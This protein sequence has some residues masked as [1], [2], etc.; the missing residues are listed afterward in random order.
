MIINPVLPLWLLVIMAVALI[1]FGI[2]QVVAAPAGKGL[3]RVWILRVVMV[4]LL[5]TVAIRPTIPG[6]GQGPTVSGGLEVYFVVD[7]TSSMAAEDYGDTYVDDEGFTR[8]ETRLD[9]VKTDIASIAEQLEGAEFSLVTFDAVAIQRVPLTSDATALLSATSVMRQEI[10]GY[11]QGSSIDAPLELVDSLLQ[12]AI[13]LNPDRDRVVFYFGDGEQT[14]GADPESFAKLAGYIAGGA[15]LGY[16]TAEGG[17]MVEF[18]G[19]D[20]SGDERYY[21]QDYSLSPVG[22]AISRIDEEKLATI[23]SDLGVEYTHRQAG[24]SAAGLVAGIDVGELLRDEGEP[25]Q[26]IELYWIFAIPLGLL[27]LLEVVPIVAT[28]RELRTTRR[29]S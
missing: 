9:G 6:E 2:W 12:D 27:V 24:D 3:R 16:G 23:A 17:P 8:H 13:E 19:Y 29:N 7:T 10:S 20:D 5:L 26:A 14:V 28:L 1:A 15:V 21:I 4:A 22:D 18:N 11:S 25:D